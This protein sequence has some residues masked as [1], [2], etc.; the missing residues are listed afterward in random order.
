MLTVKTIQPTIFKIKPVQSAE[1]SD[2]DKIT[3]PANTESEIAWYRDI[4]THVLFE[5]K[6]K[7][8]GR[9][10]WCAFEKHIQIIQDG[11]VLEDFSRQ[12]EFTKVP[13]FWDQL[14]NY[15]DP[16]RT[17]NCSATAMA[18]KM[19]GVDIASDDE[20]VE[21]VFKHGDTTDHANVDWVVNH[22]YKVKTRFRYDMSFEDLDAELAAGKPVVLG[23]LH[24]GGLSNPYGGHMV[25]CYAKEGPNYVCHDPYGS[26]MNAYQGPVTDGKAARYPDWQL[27]KRWCPG[28]SDG[29]GRVFPK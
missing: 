25:C 27:Q 28:G 13:P 3:S 8:R 5:L 9:H 16:N 24:K 20:L 4:G 11:K 14:G 6:Q 10:N 15:R 23:I 18:L 29:W 12:P 2:N 22:Y 26:L 21:R 17:C 1:L 19:I 7:A